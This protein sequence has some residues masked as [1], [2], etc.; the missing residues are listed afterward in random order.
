MLVEIERWSLI[1]FKSSKYGFFQSLIWS[2]EKPN[3]DTFSEV[4]DYRQQL[5]THLTP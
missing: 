5:W 4:Y 1:Q 3:S 2:K